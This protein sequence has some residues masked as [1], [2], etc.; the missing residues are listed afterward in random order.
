MWVSWY[1]SANGT[2]SG[3]SF[4]G[5]LLIFP[6]QFNSLFIA[7]IQNNSIDH[8]FDKVLIFCAYVPLNV[9][10]GYFKLV[11]AIGPL[12]TLNEQITIPLSYRVK[13]YSNQIRLQSL[14]QLTPVHIRRHVDFYLYHLFS[15]FTVLSD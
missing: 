6:I 1:Q 4:P 11:S 13:A 2:G 3:D 7:H 5:E 14:L 12:L 10:R 9:L 15:S 8:T